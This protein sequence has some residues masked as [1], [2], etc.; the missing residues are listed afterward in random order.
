MAFLID[1]YN[2]LRQSMPPGLAG[3]DEM[4]L[5][6]ALVRAGWTKRG[7]TLVC[8]GAAKPH[9]RAAVPIPG[10]PGAGVKVVY[11]GKGAAADPVIEDL[12]Q[13][14]HSP[15]SLTLVSDDRELQRAARRRGAQAMP[16][17][18]FIHQLLLALAQE[19]E[20]RAQRRQPTAQ[21]KPAKPG[22]HS[23]EMQQWAKEFGVDPDQKIH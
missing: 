14:D 5:C 12:I 16:C 23:D 21:P 18:E 9:F 7:V 6:Q 8:D 22:P 15:R 2:L 19:G 4:G 10:L 20:S 11:A 3:L 17:Q 1:T 13:R